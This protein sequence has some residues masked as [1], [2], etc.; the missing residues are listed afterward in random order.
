LNIYTRNLGTSLIFVTKFKIIALKI[1]KIIALKINK[2]N[3]IDLLFQDTRYNAKK[4]F[5]I[6]STVYF[7]YITNNRR[8]NKMLENYMVPSV[9]IS[10]CFHWSMSVIRHFYV[11]WFFMIYW[12]HF[13]DLSNELNVHVNDHFI[14]ESLINILMLIK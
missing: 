4:E 6:Y 1:N 14:L 11:T 5:N 2:N 12:S 10:R 13:T 8:S 9:T 3:C 7:I